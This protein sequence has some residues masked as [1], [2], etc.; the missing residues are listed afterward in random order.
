MHHVT[1][2]TLEG[3]HAAIEIAG[4]PCIMGMQSILT[5]CAHGLL[6]WCREGT[7][8]QWPTYRVKLDSGGFALRKC[9]VNLLLAVC[10]SCMPEAAI[11]E[12]EEVSV[13]VQTTYVILLDQHCLLTS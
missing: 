9:A 7:T 1:I 6:Y 3:Y 5:S 11:S 2:S 4:S 12:M 8:K 10:K 13:G